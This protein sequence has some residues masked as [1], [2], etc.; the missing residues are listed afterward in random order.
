[1]S[2]KNLNNNNNLVIDNLG[3]NS[4]ITKTNNDNYCHNEIRSSFKTPNERIHYIKKSIVNRNSLDS[5]IQSTKKF[6]M[7]NNAA[8]VKKI[9]KTG[10]KNPLKTIEEQIYELV[11]EDL[12]NHHSCVQNPKSMLKLLMFIP[13]FRYYFLMNNFTIENSIASIKFGMYITLKK[14][15]FLFNQGDKTDNFYLVLTGCIG[16][17]LSFQDK[18]KEEV[19]S[20]EVNNIKGGS[21]FGEWG[22]IYNI[23]RTVSAYAKENSIL[24]SFNKK[25][26]KAYF[27]SNIIISENNIKNFVLKHIQT[28]KNLNEVLF[29]QYYREMKKIYCTQGEEIFL[30]GTEANAFYLIYM[31]SCCVKKGVTDIIIKD[32]GDFIG[33]ECFFSDKYEVTIHPHSEGTILFKFL[34]NSIGKQIIPLLREEFESYYKTQKNILKKYADNYNKLKIKYKL[35]YENLVKDHEFKQKNIHIDCS[36]IAKN[37]S[38]IT[39]NNLLCC[40]NTKKILCIKKENFIKNKKEVKSPKIKVEQIP[41]SNKNKSR[42]RVYTA[43]TVK[44]RH[45]INFFENNSKKKE[46][47]FFNNSCILMNRQIKSAVSFKRKIQINLCKKYLYRNLKAQS[48]IHI[49]KSN[50]ENNINFIV[51]NSCSKSNSVSNKIHKNG[52]NF[53]DDLKRANESLLMKIR[54]IR[55]LKCYDFLFKNAKYKKIKNTK[56]KLGNYRSNSAKN[57]RYKNEKILVDKNEQINMNVNNKEEVPLIQILN[58]VFD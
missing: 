1:M 42:N 55:N 22:L 47:K 57:Y 34:I 30:K 11:K 31:G 4:N 21:F 48:D 13:I 50:S 15:T 44:C 38:K 2:R 52:I 45:K 53:N 32:I 41:V 17:I 3:N 8:S 58:V 12:K 43:R 37:C 28:F 27:Q 39:K 6:I 33:I 26:F 23:N 40:T 9:M 29:N 7:E 49:N 5:I 56:F 25:L 24:L 16:F 46:K 14:N 51:N 54:N 35:N 10:R 18:E 20:R 19:I 36:S